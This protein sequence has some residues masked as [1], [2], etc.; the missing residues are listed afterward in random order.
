VESFEDWKA[1]FCCGGRAT[2]GSYCRRMEKKLFRREL[3]T[4]SRQLAQNYFNGF[5]RKIRADK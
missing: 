3:A 4:D 2:N 5:I 1:I